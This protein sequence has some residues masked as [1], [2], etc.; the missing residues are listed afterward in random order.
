ML[1][2]LRGSSALKNNIYFEG[3]KDA[4]KRLSLILGLLKVD[5]VASLS[6]SQ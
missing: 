5:K 1:H 4:V 6:Q 3:H 2:R